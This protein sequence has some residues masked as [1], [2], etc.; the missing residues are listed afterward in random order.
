MFFIHEN[1]DKNNQIVINKTKFLK[2]REA[3]S[4]F[5]SA[6]GSFYASNQLTALKSLGSASLTLKNRIFAIFYGFL[7]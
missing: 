7:G 4:S 1:F 6:G 3:F 5:G 2:V